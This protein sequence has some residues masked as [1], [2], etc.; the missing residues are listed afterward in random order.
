MN[1]KTSAKTSDLPEIEANDIEENRQ[2]FL[3][4]TVRRAKTFANK[5]KPFVPAIVIGVAAAFLFWKAA[6][7][8]IDGE[9]DSEGTTES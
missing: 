3:N 8:S 2:T 5:A 1:E 7:S 9:N 6:H 4:K